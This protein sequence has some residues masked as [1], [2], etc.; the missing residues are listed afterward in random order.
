MLKIEKE[1]ELKIEL[2]DQQA[3]ELFAKQLVRHLSAP[4]VLAFSGEIG[5]GK[6]T[7]IRA[8]LL[9]LGVESRIKSQPFP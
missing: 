6:T 2:L 1:H 9:G 5:T 8:M 3:S 4:L 7:L